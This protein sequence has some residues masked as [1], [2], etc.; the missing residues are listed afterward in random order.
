MNLNGSEGGTN[1]QI[2]MQRFFGIGS[3]STSPSSPSIRDGDHYYKNDLELGVMSSQTPSSS[4]S[5][6]SDLEEDN[7]ETSLI[8]RDSLSF[9]ASS[10]PSSSIPSFSTELSSSSS[11]TTSTSSS[12]S[13]STSSSVSL[14]LTHLS[15]LSSP[16]SSLRSP[17]SALRRLNSDSG[18]SFREKNRRVSWS[19]IHGQKNLTEVFEIER[20]DRKPMLR[21]SDSP[22]TGNTPGTI[23]VLTC[24]ILLVVALIV[25]L[26]KLLRAF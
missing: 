11:S 1:R 24:I 19:D 22:F 2:E 18:A 13:A 16:S 5:S 10:S 7:D 26:L 9:S 21:D 6:M 12:T 14:N 20:Y 15:S 25:G 23:A 3:S 4:S 17:V 8:H